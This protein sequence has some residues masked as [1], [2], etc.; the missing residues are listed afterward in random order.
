MSVLPFDQLDGEI[1][2]NGEFLDWKDAKIHVINH[3]LHYGG[4][5]FEGERAYNGKIFKLKEHSQ[6]LIDSAKIIDMDMPYSV[7]EIVAATQ[8]TYERSG[9]DSA[10]IRPIAWR[11]SEQMGISARMTKTHLAIACWQWDDYFTKEFAEKGVS[12]KTSVWRKPAPD[13]APTASKASGLYVMGT[14][15]KH[16]AEKAGFQDALMLDYRGYVAESTGANLF[17]V[18]D[19]HIKTPIPDCFLNGITRRTVMELA[20]QR[21]YDVEECIIMPEELMQA[22]EIF[23]TGTAA[24]VTPVGKIDNKDFTI[25]AVSKQ[26]I[27]DYAALV[28]R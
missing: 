13:T 19:G 2:F 8:E 26:L 10:Y 3:G 6:R 7:D 25:G 9:F 4:S 12:L 24:E 5:V 14:M 27:E 28:R 11:G 17:M 20:R 23:L 22:D 15:A 21:G 18:K 1:W 16:E